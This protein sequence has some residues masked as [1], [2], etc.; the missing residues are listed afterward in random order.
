MVVPATSVPSARF[1]S[2]VD[3]T[4]AKMITFWDFWTGE[5]FLQFVFFFNPSSS[6]FGYSRLVFNVN[7]CSV[8]W[9]MLLEILYKIF[10]YLT[11]PKERPSEEK[12]T[13]KYR[14]KICWIEYYWW[15]YQFKK[16][17]IYRTGLIVNS[18]FCHHWTSCWPLTRFFF[19]LRTDIESS[20]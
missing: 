4:L 3:L 16:V 6:M 19:N 8:I 17:S 15:E 1:Y 14:L 20:V 13:Q 12:M 5:S 10:F 7:W 11:H 2:K 18:C 9:F